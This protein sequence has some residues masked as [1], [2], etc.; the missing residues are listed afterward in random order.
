MKIR[1]ITF[2]TFCLIVI[3]LSACNIP[4]ATQVTQVSGDDPVKTAAAQTVAALTTQIAA[5]DIAN[6]ALTPSPQPTNTPFPTDTPQPTNTP[7]PTSTNT[8]IG[9]CDQAGFV[10]ETVED[11]SDFAPNKV[12]TK[13]WTIKNTGTC[14]WNSSYAVVF[15]S[16]NNAM[17]APA[18]KQLTTG[19]VAPGQTVVISMD[20]TS[21]SAVGNYKAEFKLRNANGVIF[22]FGA[23]NRSF[24]VQIDVVVQS[25][26][27]AANLC[28]AVWTSGAGTLPCPGTDGAINGYAYVDPAPKLEGNYQDNEPAIWMGPQDVVDGWIKGTYPAV[29]VTQGMYFYTYIG[30]HPAATNC[31][32]RIRLNY[33]ADGGPEQNLFLWSETNDGIFKEIKADISSLV[34]KSVQFIFVVEAYGSPNDDKVHFLTPKVG[35]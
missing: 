18:A 16:G 10:S 30:C 11:N 25:Y 26:D 29:V 4:T 34:G 28:S 17:G 22:G 19:T 5:T 2:S 9:V 6:K 3:L 23:D 12:F 24:W 27:F 35:P 14:T 20:L 8:P 13:T 7:F 21:P 31:N 32:V 15:T 33:K 1:Q